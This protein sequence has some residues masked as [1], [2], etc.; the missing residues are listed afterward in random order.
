MLSFEVVDSGK[1]IQIHADDNGLLVLRKALEQVSSTGHIH[2]L[3]TANGG[4]ELDD[5][6]RLGTSRNW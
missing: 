3:S 4:N 5:T 1:A 2:L 6:N